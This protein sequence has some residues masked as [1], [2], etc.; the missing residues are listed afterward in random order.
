VDPQLDDLP[1]SVRTMLMDFIA[2]ATR[3]CGS[4]LKSVVLFGSAAEGRL[5]PTSDVNLILVF[6]EIQLPQLDGLRE[7]LS[8]AYAA[9]RLNVMFLEE[10]EISIAAQAFGVKFMDILARHRVLYGSDVF[11]SLNITREATLQRV[12][13][14]I[15]NLTLRLR[16]KYALT[17]MRGEQ[18]SQLIAEVSGPIRACA[19]AIL[20]LA[21]EQAQSPKEA[22]QFLVERLLGEN[23]TEL[24]ANISSAREERALGSETSTATIAGLLELL[25][26]MY[27][28]A[29]GLR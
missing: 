24:L 25:H 6:G 19:A 17:G 8:F 9:I 5:R 7:P 10:G 14:V 12:Q 27:Q 4:N 2:A 16:E 3:S 22:L 15:I 20:A 11:A 18:L 13:Q 29:H 26:L 1:D 28:Y 23:R 21:G